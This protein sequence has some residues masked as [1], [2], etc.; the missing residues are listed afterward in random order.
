MHRSWQGIGRNWNAWQLARDNPSPSIH[1]Y[2]TS[3]GKKGRVAC[4]L[5]H[6]HPSPT[7]SE[8]SPVGG[9]E[10][11]LAPR[12]DYPRSPPPTPTSIGRGLSWRARDY[13]MCRPIGVPGFSVHP[14]VLHVQHSGRTL[15]LRHVRSR[16]DEGVIVGRCIVMCSAPKGVRRVR[17]K[18]TTLEI[19]TF[20][21]VLTAPQTGYSLF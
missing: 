17:C 16:S 5:T 21:S 11:D 20:A 4:C 8:G 10:F 9:C 13:T 1:T 19:R 12:L 14:H 3:Q 2:R 6:K 15:S 7:T 18:A